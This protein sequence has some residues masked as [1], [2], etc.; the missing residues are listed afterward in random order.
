MSG[1]RLWERDGEEKRGREWIERKR[2]RGGRNHRSVKS[3]NIKRRKTKLLQKL[4]HSSVNWYRWNWFWKWN[5]SSFKDRTAVLLATSLVPT[6][7]EGTMVIS[8]VPEQW[9]QVNNSLVHLDGTIMK[10]PLHPYWVNWLLK[11]YLPI[12]LLFQIQNNVIRYCFTN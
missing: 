9:E 10:A 11:A 5:R 3:T 6:R 8:K 2:E 12:Y 4:K 7:L 1:G